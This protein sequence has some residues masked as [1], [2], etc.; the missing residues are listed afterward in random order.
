M[1]SAHHV[2]VW[3]VVTTK[4]SYVYFLLIFNAQ[5]RG[6]LNE[7]SGLDEPRSVGILVLLL[8]AATANRKIISLIPPEIIAIARLVRNKLPSSLPI[9]EVEPLG[10]NTVQYGWSGTDGF[11][12]KN[13]GAN[14]SSEVHRM[15]TKAGR[16]E[17]LLANLDLK[18]W[19]RGKVWEAQA[20][21]LRLDDGLE[22]TVVLEN[23]GGQDTGLLSGRINEHQQGRLFDSGEQEVLNTVRQI[24]GNALATTSLLDMKAFNVV[25]HRLR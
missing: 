9:L 12:F 15:W 3:V 23:D 13:R 11:P 2:L 5:L 18:S 6:L 14:Q 4:T 17:H 7:D 25:L 21:G 19:S 22:S 1:L 24:V 10:F 20:E 8:S 16:T